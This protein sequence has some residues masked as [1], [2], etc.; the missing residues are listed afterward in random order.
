MAAIVG[1]IAAILDKS[2]IVINKGA[3]DGIE[4]GNEFYVYTEIGPFIDP[5][6]GEDL[7]TTKKILGK[8]EVTIVEERFAVAE[9]GWVWRKEPFFGTL[10]NLYGDKVKIELPVS[11]DDLRQQWQKHVKVGTTVVSV[12][13]TQELKLASTP[14]LPT[15]DEKVIIKIDV[16]E[17][18]SKDQQN[19]EV[20]ASNI[21][22]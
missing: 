9:T 13:Q 2:T 6:T 16:R 4:R 14:A 1:K 3:A 15:S 19:L 11:S 10:A 5:D 8:V 22:D 20:Q 7:G 12:A 21:D 17:A 18:S